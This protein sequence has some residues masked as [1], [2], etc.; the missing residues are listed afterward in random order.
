MRVIKGSKHISNDEWKESIR[1]LSK[2]V[3]ERNDLIRRELSASDA[4][5]RLEQVNASTNRYRLGIKV[6]SRS[7]LRLDHLQFQLS[8]APDGIEVEF[9]RRGLEDIGENNRKAAL[10]GTVVK[11]VLDVHPADQLYSKRKYDR[12][13]NFV[14]V[15]ATYVYEFALPPGVGVEEVRV[16]AAFNTVTGARYGVREDSAFQIDAEHRKNAVWWEPDDYVERTVRVLEGEVLLEE[17]LILDE[18]TNLELKPGTHL[19][20]NPGV[21]V[22][23]RGGNITAIGSKEKPIVIEPAVAHSPWGVIAVQGGAGSV[24]RHAQIRGG[25][26]DRLFFVRYAGPLSFH[27]TSAEISDCLLDDSFIVAERAQL[28]L[29]RCTV[30][31][32]FPFT[33]Q[34]RNSSVIEDEVERTGYEPVHT[35]KVVGSAHGTPVRVEREFKYSVVS[36]DSGEVSLK[37]LAEDIRDALTEAVRDRSQW[38]AEKFANNSYYADQEVKDFVFR[39]VYFDTPDNLNHRHQVSYRLQEPIQESQRL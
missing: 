38:K 17:D 9:S 16:P 13:R 33:V 31:N 28:R 18:F 30:S 20:M 14:L 2:I 19:R 22:L 26:E 8:G 3:S 7:G 29:N 6:R 32:I 21:S 39:D 27:N 11:G 23:L 36:G 25:S 10:R 12:R 24:F 15:P 37:D 5:Y 1:E 35:A 4:V 34:A